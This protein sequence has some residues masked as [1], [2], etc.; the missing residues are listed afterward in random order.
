MKVIFNTLI[1]RNYFKKQ[2]QKPNVLA[3]KGFDCPEDTFELK[4]LYNIPCPVCS[5]PMIRRNQIDDFVSSTQNK[6]GEEYDGRI[7]KSN[8]QNIVDYS[9]ILSIKHKIYE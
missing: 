8:C 5:I 9:I 4:N 2:E 1:T 3:F 6:T 7:K